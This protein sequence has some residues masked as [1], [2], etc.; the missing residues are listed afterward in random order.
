VEPFELEREYTGLEDPPPLT[1]QPVYCTWCEADCGYCAD[2]IVA[3][4]L[5]FTCIECS[6]DAYAE[7]CRLIE[8]EL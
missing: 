1:V 2:H 3:S 8:L 6:Q 5:V 4:G 7:V